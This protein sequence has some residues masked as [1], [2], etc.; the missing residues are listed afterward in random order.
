[1]RPTPPYFP[2]SS[3]G[4]SLLSRRELLSGLGTTALAGV[5]PTV[6]SGGTPANFQG[7]LPAERD[8]EGLRVVASGR[9][10]LEGP[11]AM[12]DGSVIAV[13]IDKGNV[14]RI[15]AAGSVSVVSHVGGGPNGAKVGPDGA[16]YVCNNG[17]FDLIR[18][19]GSIVGFVKSTGNQGGSIQ[20]VDL[21]S[22]DHRTLYDKVGKYRLKAPNDLVIDAHG[23][24]WF[25]D[26]G[27]SHARNQDHG[28]VYWARLD[29][30][31]IREV[32]YP[33]VDPNG[34]ALSRDGATLYVALSGL[35]R[36]VSFEITG[37][38]TLRSKGD[39]PLRKVVASLGGEALFDGLAL[40]ASGNLVA[41]C[42][43]PGNIVVMSS[44]G[45]VLERWKLPEVAATNIAFGGAG[46]RTVF[47][48]VA[49]SGK[50]LSMPWPRAGLAL[51]QVPRVEGNRF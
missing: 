35:R 44:E 41:V 18:A 11:V 2:V 1:M 3:E 33:I 32:V 42:F 43:L 15:D 9:G 10:F 47:V 12:P 6:A 40:E 48:T 5:F 45:E 49:G 31:E 24:F 16:C 7:Q 38:G 30:S 22:G 8:I 13:E 20:R 23:G 26:F 19:G 25:T 51:N 29:G 36:I 34:I 46:L 27:F 17:G 14:I 39:E 4:Q 28:G 37:P 50:L 21:S